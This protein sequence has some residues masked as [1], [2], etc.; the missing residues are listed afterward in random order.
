MMAGHCYYAASSLHVRSLPQSQTSL[1]IR[2]SASDA[3]DHHPPIVS[4]KDVGVQSVPS[5]P[6]VDKCLLVE[7][8]NPVKAEFQ[9]VI[10]AA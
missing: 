10:P 9:I 7:H 8:F 2:Q 6:K 3:Q 4:R 5:S 1:Q